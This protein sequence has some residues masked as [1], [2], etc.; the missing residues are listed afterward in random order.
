MIAK[1]KNGKNENQDSSAIQKE[2]VSGHQYQIA[3]AAYYIAE[4]RGFV[5]EQE[6]ND[7]LKAEQDIMGNP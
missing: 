1:R 4:K 2:N 7:C 5:T 3:M 6:L